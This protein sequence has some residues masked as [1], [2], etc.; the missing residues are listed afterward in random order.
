[1]RLSP[2]P[3]VNVGSYLGLLADRMSPWE[4]TF[5]T[6][7][8]YFYFQRVKVSTCSSVSSKTAK[9]DPTANTVTL[10]PRKP[11]KVSARYKVMNPYPFS[12][13]PALSDLQGVPLQGKASA[14]ASILI[15]LTGNRSVSFAPPQPAPVFNGS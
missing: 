7:F 12:K 9:Y 4:R 6:S 15:Q 10:I 5:V 14:G 11:L 8:D 2:L 1:M 3:S 13:Q